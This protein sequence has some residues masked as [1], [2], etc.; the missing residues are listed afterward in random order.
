MCLCVLFCVSKKCPNLTCPKLTKNDQI[1]P[2][3]TNVEKWPKMTKF[4][5]R[6][7]KWYTTGQPRAAFDVRG[8]QKLPE[9][10]LIRIPAGAQNCRFSP[11]FPCKKS[12]IFPGA[13]TVKSCQISGVQSCH[14][15]VCTHAHQHFF[16]VCG[17]KIFSLCV[18][19]DEISFSST[20]SATEKVFS[21]DAQRTLSLSCLSVA[22]CTLFL[23]VHTFCKC[24]HTQRAQHWKHLVRANNI[25]CTRTHAHTRRA[26]RAQPKHDTRTT[27]LL[28]SAFVLLWLRSVHEF[29][30]Y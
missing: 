28:S 15:S 30:V 23:R 10:A 12:P 24:A 20:H 17:E 1:W 18:L 13:K 5:S 21:V 7:Q 11:V 25:L 4:A 14:F 26:H 19:C 9:Y 16:L 3:L 29:M 27:T 8:W 2:K 22:C 6:A